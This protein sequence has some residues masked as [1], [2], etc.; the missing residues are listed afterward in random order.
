MTRKFCDRSGQLITAEAFTVTWFDG[1]KDVTSD[2]CKTCHDELITWFKAKSF[3]AAAVTSKLQ[4]AVDGIVS[5]QPIGP[6]IP[7]R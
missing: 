5:I 3:D 6:P 1:T 4:T 7:L 2:L